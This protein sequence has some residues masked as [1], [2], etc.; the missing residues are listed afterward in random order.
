MAVSATVV[1]VGVLQHLKI[2]FVPSFTSELGC[3]RRR[4]TL[5]NSSYIN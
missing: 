3:N 1:N 5:L 2:L 4:S